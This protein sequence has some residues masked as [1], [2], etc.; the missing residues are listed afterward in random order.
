MIKRLV[1][2]VNG[3]KQLNILAPSYMCSRIL[4]KPLKSTF[5]PGKRQK[6]KSESFQGNV[7][8]LKALRFSPTFPASD[9]Y[10]LLKCF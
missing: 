2:I 4:N 10:L 9:Y 7:N 5:L 8:V 1:T 3:L 6:I